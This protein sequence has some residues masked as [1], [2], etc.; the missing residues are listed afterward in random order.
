MAISLLAMLVIADVLGREI[1]SSGIAWAQKLAVYLMIWA[2]FIGASLT[3]TTGKHL[4]PEVADKLWK[5]KGEKVFN[6]L[7]YALTAI[8]CLG[9]AYYSA[10]YTYESFD[11]GDKNPILKLPL[12]TVQ[13]VMPVSFVMIA[14]KSIFFTIDP[15]L[16]PKKKLG[17]H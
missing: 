1:A 5:G 7:R 17:E 13:I 10:L 16:V 11:L 12:W 8:F 15:N 9:A 14:L 6:H 2:G 3:T 4:R